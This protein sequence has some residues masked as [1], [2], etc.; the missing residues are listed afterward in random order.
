MMMLM[1]MLMMKIVTGMVPR[2]LGLPCHGPEVCR[3]AADGVGKQQSLE[4]G[5]IKA[6]PRLDSPL[7]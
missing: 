5:G 6:Q 1:M 7:K 3:K 4:H 2:W